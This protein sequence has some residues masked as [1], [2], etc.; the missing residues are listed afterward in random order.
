MG[1]F[2]IKHETELAV[3]AIVRTANGVATGLGGQGTTIDWTS[4]YFSVQDAYKQLLLDSKAKVRIVTAAPEV[5]R[6]VRDPASQLLLT[7]RVAGQRLLRVC[8]RLALFATRV[9]LHREEVLR[10]D[11]RART[12]Q[13]ASR[14]AHRYLRV[15]TL[16]MDIPRQGCAL[17]TLERPWTR[18]LTVTAGVW[19]TPSFS[20]CYP[21]YI[22]RTPLDD[23]DEH[24]LHYLSR[25]PASPFLTLVGSS[26]Y[27]RRSAERDLEANLLVT[28]FSPELRRALRAEVSHLREHALTQVNDELFERKDRR[29]PLGVKVAATAIRTML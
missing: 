7:M 5:S 6:A 13:E 8:R 24:D 22:S 23:P 29:V 2:D 19:L 27:G 11:R 17:H 26:N 20:A 15:A 9:Y 21:D 16:C 25:Y 18:A 3:P 10:R 1:P 12:P 14:V 4:G 28:T